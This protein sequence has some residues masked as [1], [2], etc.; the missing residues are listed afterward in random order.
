MHTLDAKSIVIIGFAITISV[1]PILVRRIGN[2]A[3][4]VDQHISLI[5]GRTFIEDCDGLAIWIGSIASVC[6]IIKVIASIALLTNS[7]KD[8]FTL[9]R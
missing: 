7:T 6:R 5:A 3:I 2:D 9:V 1:L 8:G 4:L